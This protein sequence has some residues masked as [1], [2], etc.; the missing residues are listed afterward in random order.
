MEANDYPGGKITEL[1]GGGYRFDAGPSLFTMPAFVDE[2]FTLTGRNPSDYYEYQRKE[3]ACQYFWEDGTELTAWSDVQKFAC[4]AAQKTGVEALAVTND[5]KSASQTYDAIKGVFLEKSLHRF[6]NYFHK[7]VLK[8]M[9]NLHK[10]HLLSTLHEVNE[11]KL[12]EPKMTQ[13]FNRFATYNGSDPYH[14]PGVM[15]LIPHLEHNLGTYYPKGGMHQVVMSLYQLAIDVGVKFYFNEPVV[16]IKVENSRVSGVQ[17]RHAHYRA[18]QVFS[19]MDVVPT[20]RKL[21]ADQPAPERTLRQPR[22]S[23]ALIFYWGIKKLFPKLDLHNIFFSN[24][25]KSEF[26]HLSEK[27]EVY[28]DPTVYIN[29]TSKEDTQDAPRDCE[30]WF[31]MVNVPPNIGQN[32]DV[33]I[34]EVRK[35]VISKLN[36][37]L[38][39]DLEKLIDYESTLDPRDIEAKTS[40]YQGALYGASS[41]NTMAAFLRH[42]NFNP[43]N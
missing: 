31:V 38:R 22:S 39:I 43:E 8:A 12:K 13:L 18:D 1:R 42:P 34:A 11:A 35:N 10:L 32:W 19:N 41:N 7:D 3:I 23:S 9:V 16:N 28:D 25:Y 2:L 27:G 5:L 15:H 33:L 20:Y 29:I 37:M 36:R 21:L 6:E 26:N 30:N 24:N 14:T 40:S 4:R 17:T